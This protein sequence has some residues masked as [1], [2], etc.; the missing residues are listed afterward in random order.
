[1]EQRLRDLRFLDSLLGWLVLRG[2]I[3]YWLVCFLIGILR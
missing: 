2:V 3:I 1:M